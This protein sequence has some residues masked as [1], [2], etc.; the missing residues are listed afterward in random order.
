MTGFAAGFFFVAADFA[1]EL[2]LG[3]R[4]AGFLI[5]AGLP[6]TG[7]DVAATVGVQ[8]N[9]SAHAAAN[10]AATDEARGRETSMAAILRA[11]MLEPA[12]R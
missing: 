11:A 2:P 1:F 3:V 6:P 4:A 12:T 5:A 9:E 10:A 7:A 8:A